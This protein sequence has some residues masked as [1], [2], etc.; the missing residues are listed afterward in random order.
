MSWMGEPSMVL[1]RAQIR[2]GHMQA[3]SVGVLTA[4]QHDA[5]P[6]FLEKEA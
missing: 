1:Y 2:Q 4:L 6:N 5:M 3:R